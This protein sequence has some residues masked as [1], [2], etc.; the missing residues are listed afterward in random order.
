ME[1][2]FWPDQDQLRGCWR[3]GSRPR[4]SGYSA[5]RARPGLSG[6]AGSSLYPRQSSSQ[7]GSVSASCRV[8]PHSA[9][10]RSSPDSS[11]TA[12]L[13]ASR[14]ASLR[15]PST[16]PVQVTPSPTLGPRFRC[17]ESLPP[18]ARCRPGPPTSAPSAPP[19]GT[20]TCR[21]T[22]TRRPTC[23]GR[24]TPM[25]I[26]WKKM[27]VTC[28]AMLCYAVRTRTREVHAYQVL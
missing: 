14:Q 19:S 8:S 4:T 16:P 21:P 7:P 23:S 1:T 24:P 2:V 15:G 9:T 27:T 22:S 5:A 28:Y 11:V 18:A 17:S 10:A 25:V 12:T 3:G 20:L 6:V 13:T 26:S